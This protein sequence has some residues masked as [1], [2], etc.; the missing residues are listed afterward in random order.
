MSDLLNDIN[1]DI[2]FSIKCPYQ[3]SI[4]NE[5]PYITMDR[6]AIIQEINTRIIHLPQRYDGWIKLHQPLSPAMVSYPHLIVDQFGQSAL[7]KQ[8]TSNNNIKEYTVRILGHVY[9]VQQDI[10]I[11]DVIHGNNHKVSE[12]RDVSFDLIYQTTDPLTTSMLFQILVNRTKYIPHGDINL[13]QNYIIDNPN[14]S[15]EQLYKLYQSKLSI[16]TKILYGSIDISIW[17]FVYDQWYK[18]QN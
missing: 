3:T 8:L 7:V 11:M 17:E 1:L 4:R 2:L 16:W 9:G 14:L 18:S 5:V 15:V 12:Q 10:L 6:D 13:I